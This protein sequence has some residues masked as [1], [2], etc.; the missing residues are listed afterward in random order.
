MILLFRKESKKENKINAH[1]IVSM[2]LFY[3]LM[4]LFCMRF[5]LFDSLYPS[6][7]EVL[8]K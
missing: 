6:G 8:S 3:N 2:S 1:I 7:G 4:L 5:S